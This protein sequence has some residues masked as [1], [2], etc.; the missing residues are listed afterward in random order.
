M[1]IHLTVRKGIIWPAFLMEVHQLFHSVYLKQA[2]SKASLNTL[3]K[4]SQAPNSHFIGVLPKP[5][6]FVFNRGCS[7]SLWE[8]YMEGKSAWNNRR[9]WNKHFAKL[10]S[11]Q[12]II[13]CSEGILDK[14]SRHSGSEVLVVFFLKVGNLTEVAFLVVRVNNCNN[15]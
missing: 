7:V 14:K 15:N 6:V 1:S 9:E 3:I 13:L 10:L 12:R 4:T 5:N 11:W 8:R 2:V